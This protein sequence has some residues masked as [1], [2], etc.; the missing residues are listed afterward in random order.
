MVANLL[1]V[2][3]DGIAYGSVLFVVSV[4]LSVTLGLMNF[5]N[6]A[7]GAFAMFGGY[8]CL[9]ASTRAGLPFPAALPVAFIATAAAGALLEL[10]FYRRLYAAG[11]LDQVLFT[12]GLALVA[13]SGAT[14][15]FGPRQLAV[16]IPE[17][18]QG[19]TAILGLEVGVYRLFLIGFVIVIAL[20]LAALVNGTRFG[21]QLR[22][23][24]DNV[25]A[26]AGSGIN[27]NR[28]FSVA[29]ALGSGLAGLGGALG[30]QV[31]SLEP[32]Y[33]LKYLVDFLLVAVLGGAGTIAGPL[34]AA[35]IIGIVDV[36]S[37]YYIPELGAFA[38]YALMPILLLLFPAGL[39]ARAS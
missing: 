7:H 23:S 39:F 1:G 35:L 28:I 9:V 30:V 20:V 8:V 38:I 26:S 24:V 33:P 13:V 34:A 6:L 37:K 32:S 15:L 22:A 5:V 16:E 17:A 36:G 27:V 19:R 29:F 3:F 14:Y 12:V 31:L 2:I 4:G 21:A 11:H 25:V 18:L 10:V